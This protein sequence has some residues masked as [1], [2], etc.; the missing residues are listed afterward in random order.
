MSIVKSKCHKK[1]GGETLKSEK[2]SESGEWLTKIKS[3]LLDSIFFLIPIKN[4]F[5]ERCYLF[6]YFLF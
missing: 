4:D 1:G 6:S 2:V 5:L 3:L